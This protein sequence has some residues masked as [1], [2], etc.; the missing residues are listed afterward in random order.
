M[1]DLRK[2]FLRTAEL[3]GAQTDNSTVTGYH[4]D[5]HYT[6]SV[7]QVCHHNTV[8]L[9]LVNNGTCLVRETIK[10]GASDKVIQNRINKI[11]AAYNG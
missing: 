5:E 4:L 6:I 11:M 2:T 3:V 10:A 7:F 9:S 1:T 8:W